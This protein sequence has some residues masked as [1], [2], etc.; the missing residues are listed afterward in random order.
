MRYDAG[1][2]GDLIKHEWLLRCLDWLPEGGCFY[3]PF[4]GKPEYEAIE[5]VRE[6]ILA[7]PAALRL[8]DAQSDAL[9]RGRYL[10]STGLAGRLLPK[11]SVMCFDEDGNK[12]TA[13]QSAGLV[14]VHPNDDDGYRALEEMPQRQPTPQLVLLDPY[15]LLGDLRG[16]RLNA[17]WSH[18]A[19]WTEALLLFILNI[20]PANR[21]AGQYSSQ[22]LA[23]SAERRLARCIVPPTPNSGIKGEQKSFV[24]MLYLP[25]KSVTP[26]S[27]NVRCR[28]LARGADVVAETLGLDFAKVSTPTY[29]R[30]R[31]EFCVM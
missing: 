6:R 19:D 10:G 31:V 2:A 9:S 5:A 25:E 21:T 13:L 3:D 1:N 20:D 29:S 27:I 7:A 8:R 14:I 4:A 28:C 30:E 26:Y 23:L 17:F 11:S 12:R 18:L 16:K 22:L 24:E 15:N